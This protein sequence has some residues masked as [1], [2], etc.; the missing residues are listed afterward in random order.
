MSR[1]L[2]ERN[3]FVLF[4]VVYSSTTEISPHDT[5]LPQTSL[6][7]IH[8]YHRDDDDDDDNWGLHTIVKKREI[9]GYS[10]PVCFAWVCDWILDCFKLQYIQ[11]QWLVAK[12]FKFYS[13][14]QVKCSKL[15]AV[16]P[17]PAG[18]ELVFVLLFPEYP[19]KGQFSS[20]FCPPFSWVP[21]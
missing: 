9:D 13:V 7:M 17:T 12:T 8:L 14:M 16:E 10:A 6:L 4:I 5:P 1:I 15:L 11:V 18:R 19:P 3:V 20:L 2:F 21:P